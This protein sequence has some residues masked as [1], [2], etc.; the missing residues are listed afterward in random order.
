[1]VVQVGEHGDSRAP[2]EAQGHMRVCGEGGCRAGLGNRETGVH[3]RGRRVLRQLRQPVGW[4]KDAGPWVLP[5]P[6][7]P[8][9]AGWGLGVATR[10]PQSLHPQGAHLSHSLRAPK[11]VDE[12]IQSVDRQLPAQH[13]HLGQQVLL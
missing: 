9:C 6:S 3:G 10:G 13:P 11:L 12:L 8:H 4:T 7:P 1:M 5:A 2:S